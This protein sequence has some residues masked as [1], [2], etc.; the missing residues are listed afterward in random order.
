MALFPP[1]FFAGLL[2]VFLQIRL[3]AIFSVA[4]A[5]VNGLSF[6]LPPDDEL[7]N[8]LN[9]RPA[10]A[11]AKGKKD[12]AGAPLSAEDKMQQFYIRV[13]KTETGVFAQTLFFELYE[14][15][16]LLT[17][18]AL[19]ACACSDVVAYWRDW[20]H[21]VA[22]S[23]IRAAP[24][25]SVYGLLSLLLICLWFPLQVKFAQ[26]LATYES[27][28]GLGLGALSFII[29]LFVI[30]APKQLFDF[31]LELATELVGRRLEVVFRAVGFVDGDI[32]NLVPLGETLR[33]ATFAALAAMG[34]VFASTA[35]LPAFR[36]ARMYTE[37]VKDKQT[38]VV[39]K[40]LLHLNVALPLVAGM[41]WIKP[42]STDLIVPKTLAPCFPRAATRD[43]LADGSAPALAWHELTETQWHSVR[44]YVVLLTIV[45]R[46]ACFRSHLQQFLV[47]PKDTIVQLVRRPGVIDGELIQTKVR[48]QFNYVPII[49]IQYL[50]PV[51]A[52]L[53]SLLLLARQTATSFGIF[54]G[55]AFVLLKAGAVAL[56]EGAQGLAWFASRV[57]LPDPADAPQLGGFRVGDDLSK[58]KISLV[59]K[60]MNDFP[61]VTAPCY[62]SFYGF[63]LWWFTFMWFAMTFAGFIYWKN[64]PHAATALSSGAALATKGGRVN[65]ETPKLLKNQ[66]KGLKLKKH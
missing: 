40:L 31:D 3:K 5:L 63:L 65:R 11:A 8:R 14:M 22:A 41:C 54:D 52:M 28:L 43:C 55:V 45:V 18:S 25:V 62:A 13:A 6:F 49:A 66:L 44:L 50:A 7:I 26:G 59:V 9:G 37:M 16:V 12:S 64:V 57:V 29:A 1:D 33:V 21:S 24:E 2:A 10:G 15:M 36:F 46:L 38:R 61:V 53:A 34:G 20:G 30:F 58:D 27:R 47:E 4:S 42:L 60:G 35:F 17:T 56:P 48:I 51:G 39:T 32:E 23:A 19:V